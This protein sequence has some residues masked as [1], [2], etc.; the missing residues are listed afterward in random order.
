M[1]KNS[2][3]QLDQPG[4]LE[5]LIKYYRGII[6]TNKNNGTM[7]RNRQKQAWLIIINILKKHEILDNRELKKISELGIF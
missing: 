7:L 2:K 3:L 1:I 6:N 5:Y 4:V